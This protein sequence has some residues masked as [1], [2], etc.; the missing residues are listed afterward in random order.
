MFIKKAPK[1]AFFILSNL[2]QASSC[3]KCVCFVCAL[4]RELF[5]TEVTVSRCRLINRTLKVKHLV[6]IDR[7]TFPYGYPETE[8]DLKHMR[9]S[10]NGEVTFVKEVESHLLDDGTVAVSLHTD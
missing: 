5:T 4:P 2:L 9:I 8:A 10:E 3:A 6:R 7:V 1:G